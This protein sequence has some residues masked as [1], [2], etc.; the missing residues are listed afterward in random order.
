[1]NR[2]VWAFIV[3]MIENNIVAVMLLMS[4]SF[5]KKPQIVSSWVPVKMGYDFLLT[6]MMCR[7]LSLCFSLW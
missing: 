5:H 2:S 6:T 1:M 4:E 3:F 7:P